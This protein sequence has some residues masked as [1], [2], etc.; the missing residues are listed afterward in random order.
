MKDQLGYTM[1]EVLIAVG[2]AGLFFTAIMG[3][4]LTS[5]RTSAEAMTQQQA[6][7]YAQ[8]GIEALKSMRFSD[9]SL[10]QSGS[11]TFASNQWTL[12]MSGPETVGEIYARTVT[13]EQVE[14]DNNCALVQ[15]G[16]TVDTDTYRVTS[17]IT[18][19][20]TK[21]V[22]QAIALNSLVTNWKNPSGP[23]AT[24]SC[25]ELFIDITNIDWFGGKQLRDVFLTNNGSQT[26]EID[27]LTFTWSNASL[28]S[29]VFS[30][31]DKV[32]SSTGP[33]TPLGEQT[34]GTELDIVDIY[35][36][37]GE[38]TEMQK[39][40]FTEQMDIEGGVDLTI[41]YECEDGSTLLIGPIDFDD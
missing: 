30:G 1:L 25:E 6:V 26:I 33:G 32:W 11:L 34:S 12:G 13:V 22:Q 41:N 7:W 17:T 8:E 5:N 9:L 31:N 28:I 20:D 2:L 40:Q 16:G 19:D 24:T 3:L 15:S 38:T 4:F 39:V 18:W 23:C 21:G 27:K 37:P 35:I 14:R 36:K 29:Q 10:T